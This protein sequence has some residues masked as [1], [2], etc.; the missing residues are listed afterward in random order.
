MAL[1]SDVGRDRRDVAFI[2]SIILLVVFVINVSLGAASNSAFLSDV[3]EML[4]LL[5]AAISFVVAILKREAAAK[6]TAGKKAA[7]YSP[8]RTDNG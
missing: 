6:E 2:I 1:E 5:G 4:V 8:G 7:K 3:G